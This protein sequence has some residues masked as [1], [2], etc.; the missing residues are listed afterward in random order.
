[1]IKEN[2]RQVNKLLLV[3]K[4]TKHTVYIRVMRSSQIF[5]KILLLAG[6]AR[7]LLSK[8]ENKSSRATMLLEDNAADFLTG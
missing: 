2:Q 8:T 3:P 7:L 4:A 1:M 6:D 5:L